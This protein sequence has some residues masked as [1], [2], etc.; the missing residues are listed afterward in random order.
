MRTTLTVD[1]DVAVRL[2]RERQKR[3]VPFKTL[4]NDVL[5][6][7]LDALHQPRPRG[8]AHA[9]RGFHLGPSLVGS[10]DNIEE[11]LSRIEGDPPR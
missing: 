7:G 11:I 9:T 1:E 10:L 6:A 4:V 2:E 5:R 8:P 3:R